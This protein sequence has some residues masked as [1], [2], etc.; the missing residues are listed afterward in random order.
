MLNSG[1]SIN[2]INLRVVIYARVSTDY[3]DDK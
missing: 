1:M 2:E 3:E